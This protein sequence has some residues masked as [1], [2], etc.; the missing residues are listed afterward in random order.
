MR[1]DL[2]GYYPGD[3]QLLAWPAFCNWW[4]INTPELA[5]ALKDYESAMTS[6]PAALKAYERNAANNPGKPPAES[7]RPESAGFA[8]VDYPVKLT[9]VIIA[10]ARTSCT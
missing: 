1:V 5:Q 8:R 7:K 3:D 2:S 4:A 10:M 6:Y 9:K